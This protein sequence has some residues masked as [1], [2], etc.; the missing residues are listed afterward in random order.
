MDIIIA[1]F[2]VESINESVA[3]MCTYDCSTYGRD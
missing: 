2:N 3:A 1:G